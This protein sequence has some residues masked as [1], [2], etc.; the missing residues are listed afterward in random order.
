MASEQPVPV[1]LEPQAVAAY[2]H[3][4]ALALARFAERHELRHLACFLEMA[5]IEAGERSGA[6]ETASLRM[7]TEP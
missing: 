5:A 3:E 2:I 1:E 4:M 6:L 7:V